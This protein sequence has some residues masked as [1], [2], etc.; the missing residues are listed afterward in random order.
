MSGPDAAPQIEI[1]GDRRTPVPVDALI[2]R[3]L[4]AQ[5]VLPF[6][7]DRV[8]FLADFARRLGRRARGE[9]GAQALAYWLRKA[10]LARMRTE[11]EALDRPDAVLMPRGLTF[12]V[13]P[14][15]VDTIFVYSL[16]LALVTG[17]KSIVRM[18]SRVLAEPNLVLEV[19]LET[20]ADH[21]AAT[22]STALITYGHDD[23]ITALLSA[24]CDVR[25]IWGGDSTIERIRRAP[26]QPHARDIT[27]ADRFSLAAI[28]TDAYQSLSTD[29]RDALVE[30]FFNDTYWFDQMGCSSPRSLVWVGTGEHGHLADDFHQRLQAVAH[31]KG[32]DPD[33]SVEIAKLS[34]SY[35]SI[36]DMPVDTY[37]RY[38]SADTVLETAKFPAAR[39][40]FCGGGLLYQWHVGGLA[41]LAPHVR[42]QDQTLGVFG[43]PEKSIRE[44]IAAVAGRGIDR[45]VP[46]GKALD[47]GRFWDG[48]DLLAEFTRRVAVD[49]SG[50]T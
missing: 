8:A 15:N 2:A 42:R 25:V 40:E 5:P 31:R 20:L 4:A 44:L 45:I 12:H 10:E 1:L 11:F 13:P 18:S 7:E 39:G 9:G 50:C 17:N 48:Y 43:I 36:L 49:L 16:A 14:A 37:R 30:R 27:F 32:Y 19:L 24:A 23:R 41:D 3:I 21:P 6:D 22:D 34:H 46:I 38:G 33:A 26:L 47:F 35:R 28:A 29:E